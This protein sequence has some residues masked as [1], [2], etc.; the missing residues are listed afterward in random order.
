MSELSIVVAQ[1]FVRA[2]N[3]Q[4]VDAIAG[5]MTEGH[6]FIDS[7]GNTVTGSAAMRAGWA[8][9]FRMVPDYSIA[10]EEAY[11]DGPV[12]ILLATAQGT[13]LAGGELKPENRW[14]TP[15]AI[16]AFVE[17]SKVAEWRVYADNEPIRKLMAKAG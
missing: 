10:V 9:Y 6:R 16:R 13:Y 15:V 3:R 4:D 8:G 7:L 2:I 5:L 1:Q 12:A 17:D 11:S 14:S